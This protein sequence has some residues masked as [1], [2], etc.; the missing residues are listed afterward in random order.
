MVYKYGNWVECFFL[1]VDWKSL[2]VNL[3]GGIVACIL[4]L[5]HDTEQDSLNNYHFINVGIWVFKSSFF[6]TFGLVFT[7]GIIFL[8]FIPQNGKLKIIHVIAFSIGLL[9]FEYLVVSNGMLKHIHYSYWLSLADN[10]MVMAT[11]SW[12]KSFVLFIYNITGRKLR[13]C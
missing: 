6:F 8:Q 10:L 3:W 1:L 9:I 5:I 13:K 4:Q 11:L 2:Y 12:T 7:M